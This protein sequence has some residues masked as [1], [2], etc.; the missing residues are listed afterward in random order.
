MLFE[1][2][3]VTMEINRRY[4]FRSDL[5]TFFLRLTT[6]GFAIRLPVVTWHYENVI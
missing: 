3:V 2:A 4:Y 1:S 5:L 6:M